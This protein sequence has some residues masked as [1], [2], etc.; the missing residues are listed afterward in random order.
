LFH[1][2]DTDDDWLPDAEETG[3]GGTV[4]DADSDDCPNNRIVRLR[5]TGNRVTLTSC[6]SI[7]ELLGVLPW[8][9]VTS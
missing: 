7:K 6:S 3:Y 2:G 5:F 8:K 1:E 4:G 9:R